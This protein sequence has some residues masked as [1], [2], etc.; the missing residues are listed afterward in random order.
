[1]CTVSW[2]RHEDGGYQLLCNRDEKHTRREAAPPRLERWG[3]VGVLAP[4]DGDAGGSWIATNS[5]GV[6]LCLLN[7]TGTHTLAQPQSRGLL[8]LALAASRTAA[9]AAAYAYQADLTRTA[10][11]T[12]LALAPH[13]PAT[14]LEWGGTKKTLLLAADSLLPLVS[15]SKDPKEAVARRRAEFARLT[16]DGRS[17]TPAALRAFHGSHRDG[18]SAY[19]PCMHRA[20]ASTVSFSWIKVSRDCVDF[21]YTPG[22]PCEVRPGHTVRL[23]RT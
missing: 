4:R 3:E 18:P 22:A 15:S 7:G 11:F 13:R 2:L 6:S 17:V 23:P 20:D 14:I 16:H 9:E 21:L 10:P 19:S 8:L 5:L 1:M 12:L